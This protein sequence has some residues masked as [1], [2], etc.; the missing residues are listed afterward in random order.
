MEVRQMKLTE[1]FPMY[2]DARPRS[3]DNNFKLKSKTTRRRKPSK[4]YP[5]VTHGG[6]VAA[7]GRQ[8]ANKMSDTQR[9][10][11]FRRGMVLIYGSGLPKKAVAGH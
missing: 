4:D 10:E 2:V 8:K 3:L 6:R 7:R 5:A 9:E 11:Y 1:A